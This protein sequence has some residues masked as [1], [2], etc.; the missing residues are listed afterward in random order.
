MYK[1]INNKWL[2]ALTVSS[3]LLGCQQQSSNNPEQTVKTTKQVTV[4]D[5][6][7][8][9]AEAEQRIEGIYQY[10]GKSAW[11]AQTYI[12]QDSQY[13]ESLANKEAKLLGIEL[14]NGAAQFDQLELPYDLRRK[15]DLL[16]L[17]L[18]LPAPV[19]QPD[20][21]A[22]LAKIESEL[23]AMYGSG[24]DGAG[25]KYDLGALSKTLASSDDPEEMKQAWIA[26]RKVSP[27]MKQPY[28]RLVEIA[29]EGAQD[30][31]FKDL[32][33][34]WRSKYDMNPDQF[35]AEMDRVW[36]QVKPLYDAL[37]CH[38]RAKLNEK[39]G[40]DVVAKD[41]A[42]P[43]HLLGNMWAQTWSNIYDLVAPQSGSGVDVT[44][45]L[46]A[47][48][49]D[50]VAMVR[51]AES[52]FSSLDFAP[53]PDSFWTR[54]QFVK[55]RDRD[56]VCHASAWDIT[57]EDYRIKMCINVNE[58]DFKTIH[59]ELGHNYYQRAYNLAQP[60]LYRGSANDGF[61]EALGDTVA[62]SITPKYLKEIGLI[63]EEPDASGDLPFL[64]RMAMD[65]VSFLPFGLMVDKWRW[66]VFNGELT[67]DSYNSGWWQLREQYQGVKAPVSRTA[68]DFDA[69]AKYHVP[70]NTPYSRYFLAHILQFQ[71][72]REL[73]NTA[74][75][76][77][78][79]HRCS[80][81]NNK[82]AGKKLKAMMEM[83]Q[84]RPWQEAL[85]AMTGSKQMDASAVIDYFAPLKEWLDQQ[86][87]GRQCGW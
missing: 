15:L 52:F 65:K 41:G 12:S 69:G 32:G 35:A 67:P 19:N 58:E 22:E 37:H 40:P 44:K 68:D 25:N 45:R 63:S 3:A 16:K 4:K 6:E 59:H 85:E 34:M 21:A 36:G 8:Y 38:V 26:W 79:L 56:V 80:I 31:G 54:S 84:S 64:L 60:M 7:N 42:I 47:K 51:Q 86:N 62:L 20:K 81:Y 73:C 1:L 30:L 74:G 10:V 5:A 39:Y 77:G 29:N 46:Q 33:A 71:F 53:L 14:A 23:T 83:G 78:P 82:A 87:Q 55:P 75:H 24:D 48:S 13:I 17:G 43:A 72:H 66:Q 2:L 61:H 49:Y 11:I 9:V 18:T 28:Q 57:N 27:Q 50:A 76:Q 70:A